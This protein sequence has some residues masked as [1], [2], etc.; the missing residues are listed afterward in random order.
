MKEHKRT[1]Y[2]GY[3]IAT[4]VVVELQKQDDGTIEFKLR[5]VDGLRKQL[6][7]PK[8]VRTAKGM[9]HEDKV[10]DFAEPLVFKPSK[11]DNLKEGSL[12][13]VNVETSEVERHKTTHNSFILVHSVIVIASSIEETP[14]K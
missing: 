9:K 3:Y 10:E 5:N 7:L 4:G 14:A 2:A 12:V 1:E 11:T 8:L 13:T 6:W